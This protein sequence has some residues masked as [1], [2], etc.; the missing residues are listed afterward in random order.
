MADLKVGDKVVI[1]HPH[2][3]WHRKG[4]E[5]VI[6]EVWDTGRGTK[7][8]GIKTPQGVWDKHHLWGAWRFVAEPEPYIPCPGC[9]A[10]CDGSAVGPHDEDCPAFGADVESGPDE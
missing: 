6:T 7:L 9:G 8:Y 5:A 1:H 3:S 2:P 10:P 4:Q